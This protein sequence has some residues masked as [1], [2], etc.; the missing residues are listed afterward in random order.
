MDE[1][2]IAHFAVY[3]ISGNE[4][5]KELSND[6]IREI[7]RMMLEQ[8][9]LRGDVIASENELQIALAGGERGEELEQF[10]LDYLNAQDGGK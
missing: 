9:D 4:L 1:T 3:G 6:D 7:T 10:D 8:I 2:E 5:R